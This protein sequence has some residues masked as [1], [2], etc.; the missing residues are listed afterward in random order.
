MGNGEGNTIQIALERRKAEAAE[1]RDN[2]D[3]VLR[4]FRHRNRIQAQIKRAARLPLARELYDL[5][6]EMHQLGDVPSGYQARAE[7][8]FATLDR[9]AFHKLLEE[10]NR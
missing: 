10:G 2:A 5:V 1:R 7:L 3:P 9:A 8:I 6:L 4:D